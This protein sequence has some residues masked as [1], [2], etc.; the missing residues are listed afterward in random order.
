MA[1]PDF[2]K[3]QLPPRSF[4]KDLG[5]RVLFT[6]LYGILAVTA[7]QVSHLDYVWV[8]IIMGGLNVLKGFVARQVGSPD[9]AGFT[10]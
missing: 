2:V 4:W 8:P 5:E 6:V 7:Q 3:N 10:K 1:I 9:T